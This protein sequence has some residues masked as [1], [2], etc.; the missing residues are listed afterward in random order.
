MQDRKRKE[1]QISVYVHFL[2]HEDMTCYEMTR[3]DMKW[4][5]MAYAHGPILCVARE[6][7]VGRKVSCSPRL[8]GSQA[9]TF[10]C[11]EQQKAMQMFQILQ[12]FFFQIQQIFNQSM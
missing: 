10:N 4:Y 8:I 1:N 3:N 2:F 7:S 6:I 11:T 9:S 5:D 12:V